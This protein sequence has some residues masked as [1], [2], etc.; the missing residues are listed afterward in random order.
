MM[1]KPYEKEIDELEAEVARL[2]Q[3]R[4]NALAELER[5]GKVNTKLQEECGRLRAELDELKT[6]KKVAERR[7]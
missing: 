4:S 1:R 7:A 5:V 3:E 2:R 6:P